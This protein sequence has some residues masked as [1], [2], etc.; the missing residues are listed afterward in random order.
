MTTQQEA[1]AFANKLRS[2][3]R[4]QGPKGYWGVQLR[5]R[6]DTQ[7]DDHCLLAY[8]YFRTGDHD[9]GFRQLDLAIKGRDRNLRQMK[10]HPMWDFVRDDARFKD[11]LRRVGY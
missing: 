10:T 9:N 2:A 4:S 11:V 1:T 8:A 6:L 5:N 3:L 7:A